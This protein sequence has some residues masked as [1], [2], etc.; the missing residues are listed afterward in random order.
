MKRNTKSIIRFLFSIML[1]CFL[2][3]PAQAEEKEEFSIKELIFEHLGDSY[4]W[5][6]ISYNEKE[7]SLYLP[8]IVRSESG[9]W[10]MF[11]S[12][13]LEGGA[14][15]KGFHIAHEGDYKHKVVETTNA[16]AE[17]RPFDFSITK[18]QMV[19]FRLQHR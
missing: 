13:R 4:K 3:I 10:H 9:K 1:F 5:H 11:S 6:F 18:N 14:S 15:Y 2:I 12:S 7:V 8:V 19:V 17:I 16:G